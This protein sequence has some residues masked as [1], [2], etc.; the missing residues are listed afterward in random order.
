MHNL[1]LRQLETVREVARCG[2]MIKAA[3][4][5]CVTPA[6]LTSRVKLLEDDLGL[7]L[8]EHFEGRLRLTEA[9]KEVIAAAARIDNVISDLLGTLQGT[10]GM[11]GGRIRIGVVST[12]KYFAPRLIATFIKQHPQV[13]LRL[14]IHNRRDIVS[15]LCDYDIDIALMGRPPENFS[16]K[17]EPIGPHP[18]VIIAPP[19]HPL[20]RK[21]RIS[22]TEL[23]TQ[24]FIV[25]EEGS[26]TRS[27][28]DNFF[29]GLAM[30]SHK[31]R[32]EIGSNETIKQAVM[33]GLGISLISA[34]TIQAEIASGRLVVLKM[35]G[36]PIMRKWF[37][38]QRADRVLSPAGQ[39]MWK[40][41]V[42]KGADFL[43]Q[44]EVG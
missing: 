15:M 29:S 19:D 31:V 8:F 23:A 9:G 26:G 14:S 32:I 24:N 41:M 43:P 12:A 10:N 21:A 33:A 27:M 39:A 18:H 2:T 28:F 42:N 11:L 25:R 6:A 16:V 30:R 37:A 1:S 38:I 5:L 22:K 36:L 40:F 7:Q 35:E 44:V 4:V 17:S 3:K 34:H 20:T 13:D